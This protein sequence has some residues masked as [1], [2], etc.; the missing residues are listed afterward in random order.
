R[1]A[2]PMTGST[3][4]S[5]AAN[6]NWIASSLRSSQRRRLTLFSIRHQRGVAAG[7]GGVDGHGL[8]GRKARQVMRSTGLWTCARQSMSAERLH[9]DHRANHV[10]V[11]IDVADG[12]PADHLFD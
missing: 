12:K 5:G 9:P 2:H 7:R 8:L 1:K 4:Q 10:A 6:K 11:D 3:K